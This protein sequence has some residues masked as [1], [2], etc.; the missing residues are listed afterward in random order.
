MKFLEFVSKR[1]KPIPGIGLIRT[2][3]DTYL[4]Y[5]YYQKA[6]NKRNNHC[7]NYQLNLRCKTYKKY[8]MFMYQNRV[9]HK[10]LCSL[11]NKDVVDY[12]FHFYSI[13]K[14]NFICETDYRFIQT[15]NKYK[16]YIIISNILH[17]IHEKYHLSVLNIYKKLDNQYKYKDNYDYNENFNIFIKE[18][19]KLYIL[20]EKAFTKSYVYTDIYDL[21]KQYKNDVYQMMLMIYY[22]LKL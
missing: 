14:L 5:I 6:H 16:W 8:K 12:I 20:N 9:I 3:R 21:V 1:E 11:L 22:E 19:G 2:H 10:I 17:T 15:K 18:V 4:N 7:F 13:E